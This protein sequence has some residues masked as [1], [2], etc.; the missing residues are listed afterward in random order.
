MKRPL[1]NNL[2]RQLMTAQGHKPT[3]RIMVSNVRN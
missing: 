1:S 3:F 2:V